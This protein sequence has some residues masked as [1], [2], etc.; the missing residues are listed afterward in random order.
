[1]CQ[2]HN[3]TRIYTKAD[4]GN[5][6]YWSEE[7]CS[8]EQALRGASRGA[9]RAGSEGPRSLPG[10]RCNA[11]LQISI[12]FWT[13]LIVLIFCCQLTLTFI[14]LFMHIAKIFFFIFINM[15]ILWDNFQVFL[16]K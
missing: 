16:L 3:G 11:M 2:E 15:L 1:M 9:P 8:K 10:S 13:K 7:L 14:Q 12:I 5:S 6:G 4:R